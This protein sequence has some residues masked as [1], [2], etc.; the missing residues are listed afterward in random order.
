MIKSIKFKNFFSFQ[1]QKINLQGL[2]VFVGINGVGKSNFIKSLQV[3]KAVIVENALPDLIINQ[4]GGVDAIH[5]LGRKGGPI[6]IEYELDPVVLSQYGYRFQ[7]A[8]YY[9]IRF[10]KVASSENY[11]ISER[12]FTQTGFFYMEMERGNGFVREGVSNQMEKVQYTLDRANESVL[13]QLVDKNS[14]IQIYALRE[15]IKDIAIY[16]YFDTTITSPIRK[17][18]PAT[19]SIRLFSDGSNLPKLLN[20]IKINHKSSIQRIRE[21]LNSINP[22]FVD[23]DFNPM[24]SGLE[25][26]LEEKGLEK[27]VHVTHI[28]DGTL[29]YLCLLS[30]LHNPNRGKLICIDEP[31]VGLHPDMV[32]ELMSAIQET[33]EDT[34]YIISTHSELLLNQLPVEN[35]IVFEKDENN[36]TIVNEFTDTAFVEWASQYST[37]RLWRNGDLGGNRY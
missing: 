20:N 5:F 11:V 27:S 9:N 36:A 13:T 34:Q 22:N 24:G 19:S 14:Y 26:L 25:M 30:I 33:A 16:N 37:G 8:V 10:S 3:L 7:E 6:E 35:V 32:T 21:S 12:F 17:P 4:W 2:N 1:R 31:E 18:A 29:R 15:A 23:F 28:S